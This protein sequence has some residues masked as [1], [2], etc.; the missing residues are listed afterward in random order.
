MPTP[1]LAVASLNVI[2]VP[3]HNALV[4]L[5]T[6]AAGVALTVTTDVAVTVP[7]DAVDTV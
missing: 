5:M 1:P 6:P 7:Q 4:P 3:V 2:V